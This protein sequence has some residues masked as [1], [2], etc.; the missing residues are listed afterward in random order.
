M[1]NHAYHW[2][3]W[4]RRDRQKPRDQCP[5]SARPEKIPEFRQASLRNFACTD[6]GATPSR[7]RTR[8]GPIPAEFWK[9]NEAMF[10]SVKRQHE[11]LTMAC[12]ILPNRMDCLLERLNSS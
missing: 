11:L 7:C 2:L 5:S 3:E 9:W 6:F 1:Q 4:V 10:N 12:L 8:I